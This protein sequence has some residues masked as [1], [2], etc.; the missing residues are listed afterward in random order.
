MKLVSTSL[1]AAA[2]TAVTAPAFANVTLVNCPG[3]VVSLSDEA[4]IRGQALSGSYTA[5]ERV[6]CERSAASADVEQPIVFPVFIEELGITSRIGIF[7]TEG[8]AD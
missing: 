3:Y 2:L 1:V 4:A 8:D 6:V 7:P 5:F